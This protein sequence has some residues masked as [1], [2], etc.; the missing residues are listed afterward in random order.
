MAGLT[1]ARRVALVAKR[2]GGDALTEEEEAALAKVPFGTAL[3]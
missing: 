2:E 1:R 3:F